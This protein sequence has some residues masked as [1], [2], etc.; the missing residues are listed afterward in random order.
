MIGARRNK[1][2]LQ[3]RTRV[4]DGYGGGDNVWT[5][6]ASVWG[7]ITQ[8]SG[9]EKLHGMQLENPVTHKIKIRYRTDVLGSDR[10]V[11]KG[12]NF[13]IRSSPDQ[14]ERRRFIIIKA[15]EGVAP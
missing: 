6:Y 4:D 3:R 14:D 8:A 13:N 15:E 11:Y 2:S 9:G 5:E 1:I 12:R 10:I 7:N